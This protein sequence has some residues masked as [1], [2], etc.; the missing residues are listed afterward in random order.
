MQ[1]PIRHISYYEK[2]EKPKHHDYIIAQN[3]CVLCGTVLE[4]RHLV[5]HTEL[6]ITEE[7]HCPHCNVK[8]R[9]KKFNIH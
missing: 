1:E 5:N 6:E 3:N 8:A 4:L 9:S 7:A 2:S